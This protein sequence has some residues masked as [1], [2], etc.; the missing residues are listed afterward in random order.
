M[1]LGVCCSP[2]QD[3]RD[4]L[5]KQHHWADGETQGQRRVGQAELRQWQ[6]LWGQID[7]GSEEAV[8]GPSV[9]PS[10]EPGVSGD[11]WG[12]QEGCQGPS[13]GEGE[14]VQALESREG[15]RASRRVEEGL[16]RSLSGGGGKPR[17]EE[18]T[19]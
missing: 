17:S 7:L 14:R 3:L 1:T 10:G 18:H 16:S 4:H 2:G 15:T 5:I 9:F 13:R 12:S 19:V 11:F 8:P 6:L